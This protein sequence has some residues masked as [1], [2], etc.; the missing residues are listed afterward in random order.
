MPSYFMKVFCFFSQVRCQSTLENCVYVK[1]LKFP[2]Q[3]LLKSKKNV[4]IYNN[5]KTEVQVKGGEAVPGMFFSSTL[6]AVDL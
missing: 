1:A 6:S 5:F 2:V 3:F 4:Y